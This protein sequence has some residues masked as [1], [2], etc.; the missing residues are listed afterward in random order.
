MLRRSAGPSQSCG[1]LVL[2]LGPSV[3]VR[4]L[5]SG[6]IRREGSTDLGWSSVEN[7][8]SLLEAE[9]I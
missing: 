7:F 6:R 2:V 8:S 3:G 1:V 4:L 9:I 5:C